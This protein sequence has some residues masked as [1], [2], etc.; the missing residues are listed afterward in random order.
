MSKILE[1]EI[2]GKV[3]TPK[4][5]IIGEFIEKYFI[6][7]LIPWIIYRIGIYIITDV[8]A[9]AMQEEQ[10]S[11]SS[12]L[13]YYNLANELSYKNLFFSIVIVLAG[14]LVTNFSCTILE[15]MLQKKILENNSY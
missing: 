5:K 1:E 6:L 9:K 7:S 15:V 10:F 2:Y 13:N 4:K 8:G 11:I 12:I 14:L 3:A